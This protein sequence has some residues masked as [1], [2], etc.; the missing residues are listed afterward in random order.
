M[1]ATKGFLIAMHVPTS[2]VKDKNKIIQ[3][4]YCIAKNGLDIRTEGNFL[5]DIK[6]LGYNTHIY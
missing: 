5:N 3:A 1:F 2:F 6:N 4:L